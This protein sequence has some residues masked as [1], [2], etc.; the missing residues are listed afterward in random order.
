LPEENCIFCQIIAEKEPAV[1]HYKSKEFVVFENNLR[2]FPVQ[3]LVVPTKH[4]M[5]NDLWS[6]SELVSNL[7]TM[8]NKIGQTHCPDGYRILSNF[9]AHGMQSQPHAHIHLIGGEELGLYVKGRPP[10]FPQ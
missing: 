5:Q 10:F 8:A 2:W 9:G 1:F 3:L 4:M 6:D 7:C